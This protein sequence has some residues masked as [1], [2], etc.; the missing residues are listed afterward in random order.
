MGRVQYLVSRYHL[1]GFQAIPPGGRKT[2]RTVPGPEPSSHVR[3]TFSRDWG[4]SQKVIVRALIATVTPPITMGEP[5]T[6]M[7]WPTCRS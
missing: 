7:V 6:V 3:D 5:V 1:A 2:S 4:W